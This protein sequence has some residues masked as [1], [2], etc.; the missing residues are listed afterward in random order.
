MTELNTK[1]KTL[2]KAI[3]SNTNTLK[4][5]QS[6][7]ERSR[8]Q[9]T[10]D[11]LQA[12]ADTLTQQLQAQAAEVEAVKAELE[13][14]RN[15]FIERLKGSLDK[16]NAARTALTAQGKPNAAR[17]KEIENQQREWRSKLEE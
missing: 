10:K 17:R 5:L 3:S 13:K 9:A 4:R 16:I 12:E 8:D 11:R 14:L 6:R 15:Q 2:S 1:H 7:R